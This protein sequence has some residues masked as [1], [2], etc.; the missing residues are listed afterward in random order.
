MASVPALKGC[1]THAKTYKE[2]IP[3]ITEAIELYIESLKAHDEPIPNPNL[4]I[5]ISRLS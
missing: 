3:R 1:H 4:T 2:L 5:S